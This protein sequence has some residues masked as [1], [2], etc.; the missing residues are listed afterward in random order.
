MGIDEGVSLRGGHPPFVQND[1]N[2]GRPRTNV[3]AG[4]LNKYTTSYIFVQN[5]EKHSVQ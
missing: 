3:A 5:D 2:F 4:I 1:E